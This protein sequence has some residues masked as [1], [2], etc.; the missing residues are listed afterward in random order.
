MNENNSK[1]TT[2]LSSFRRGNINFDMFKPE[3]VVHVE[4]KMPASEEADAR[5]VKIS[6]R[7]QFDQ[8]RKVN[9][10]SLQYVFL[11]AG[12]FVFSFS[13]FAYI[14]M[15]GRSLLWMIALP[16]LLTSLLWSLIMLALIKARPR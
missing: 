7:G 2:N 12:I 10:V 8:G 6:K 14:I 11:W 1:D 15:S 3:G 5:Y 13:A 9:P 4:K 16:F